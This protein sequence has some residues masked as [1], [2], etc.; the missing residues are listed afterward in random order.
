MVWYFI[1]KKRFVFGTSKNGII[2]HSMHEKKTNLDWKS[3]K[4]VSLISEKEKQWKGVFLV[5][6]RECFVLS[7]FIF[8]NQN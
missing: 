4:K 7:H 3:V 5:N 2:L 1:N 8:T 6:D